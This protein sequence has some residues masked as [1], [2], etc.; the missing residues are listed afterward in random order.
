MKYSTSILEIDLERTMHCIHTHTRYCSSIHEQQPTTSSKAK[1]HQ[2]KMGHTHALIVTMTCHVLSCGAHT[3]LCQYVL[4][5]TCPP[6]YACTAMTSAAYC[7]WSPRG[8]YTRTGAVRNHGTVYT[9]YDPLSSHSFERK[10]NAACITC[11]C[12]Q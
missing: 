8:P 6:T 5:P 1:G 3:L 11:A 4:V 9:Y 12:Q 10:F 2:P 7:R